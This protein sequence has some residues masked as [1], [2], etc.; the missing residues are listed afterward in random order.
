MRKRVLLA[1]LCGLLLV[2]AGSLLATD[3]PGRGTGIGSEPVFLR[4]DANGD[5][6]VQ[7]ADVVFLTNYLFASGE[8]PSCL[9]AADAND[10]GVVSLADIV[11]LLDHLFGGSARIARPFPA[12][13][14]DPTLDA[15]DC[16]EESPERQ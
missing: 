5:G 8:E 2:S 6:T 11:T 9:K 12:P 1:S 4:G 14:T 13:G 3:I 15:L 7:L 16:V 10:D